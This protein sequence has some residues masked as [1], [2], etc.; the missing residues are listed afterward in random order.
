MEQVSGAGID[1]NQMNHHTQGVL[2]RFAQSDQYLHGFQP[3]HLAG[4]TRLCHFD[5]IYSDNLSMS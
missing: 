3:D 1:K 2:S 5:S 4:L